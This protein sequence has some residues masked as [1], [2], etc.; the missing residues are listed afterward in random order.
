[1]AVLLDYI[2]QSTFCLLF[3]F[4][5]YH[6]FLRHEKALRFSRF[7]LLLTPIFALTFPLINIPVDFYKP[8]ISLEQSQ[9]FRAWT[10]VDMPESF[11]ATFGL[12]EVIVKSTKLPVLWEIKD[13]LFLCYCFV[14]GLLAVR[15]C[16][17]FVQLRLLAQKGWYQAKYDLRNKIFL[18]P[19][20]ALN[21]FFSFFNLVFWDEDQQLQPEE[22]DQILKHEIEHVRQWHSLD[23]IYFQ[24]LSI[25]FWFNPGIHLMRTSLMDVHEFLADDHVLRQTPSKEGY[26]L[27]V[28]KMA[29]KGIDLSIANYFIRSTTL[30]R[31]VMMKRTGKINW[32]KAGMVLP[33]TGMLLALVSMKTSEQNHLITFNDFESLKS[34]LVAIQ[35]HLPV[36][37]KVKKVKNIVHFENIS[38]YENNSVSAQLGNLLFEFS[39]VNCWDD[40]LKVREVIGHLR[41]YAPQSIHPLSEIPDHFATPSLGKDI[42]T[43]QLIIEVSTKLGMRY[44]G[45]KGSGQINFIVDQEGLISTPTVIKS[46]GAE[47]DKMMLSLIANEKDKWIPAIHRQKPVSS[48][49]SIYYELDFTPEHF[50]HNPKTLELNSNVIGGSNE[51]SERRSERDARVAPIKE[52]KKQVQETLSTGSEGTNSSTFFYKP[53]EK[54][55]AI[56]QKR[57]PIALQ[58]DYE[59]HQIQNNEHSLDYPIFLKENNK[60]ALDSSLTKGFEI[61]SLVKENAQTEFY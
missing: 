49:V 52:Q 41:S 37:V 50:Q 13:Y 53:Q 45:I 8:D 60:L 59:Q 15:L 39:D 48:N 61:Y 16:F 27:L 17:Q 58:P 35:K 33:L 21:N 3:F 24:V 34:E 54:T 9:L 32:F 47:F 4:G 1:M 20:F 55:V 26:L 57:T 56:E 22:Q 36:S 19:T 38:E 18:I 46:F 43:K 23:V 28:V 12:P 25:L 40:Y 42:W 7:Y 31:I 2:W 29:F 51:N 5:V 6:V 14:V 10:T 30:K 44:K 11:V